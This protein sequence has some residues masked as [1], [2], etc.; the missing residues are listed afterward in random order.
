M[1][2]LI[3]LGLTVTPKIKNQWGSVQLGKVAY[4]AGVN[5]APVRQASRWVENSGAGAGDRKDQ[6]QSEQGNRP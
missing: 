4:S 3:I 1:I 6:A 2:Q 5:P